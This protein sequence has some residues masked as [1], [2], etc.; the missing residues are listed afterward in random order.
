MET[1]TRFERIIAVNI[2]GIKLKWVLDEKDN[3][4][5]YIIKELRRERSSRPRRIITKNTKSPYEQN[6]DNG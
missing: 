3:R 2:A 4:G 1:L 5:G 6:N